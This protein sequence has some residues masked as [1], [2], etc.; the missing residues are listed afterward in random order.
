MPDDT[1]QNDSIPESELDEVLSGIELKQKL[2]KAFREADTAKSDLNE[3]FT[4]RFMKNPYD[5][6]IEKFEYNMLNEYGYKLSMWLDAIEM[7][8]KTDEYKQVIEE[9]KK[10][11][12]YKKDMINYVVTLSAIMENFCYVIARG[13][14]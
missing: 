14:Q 6:T 11:K 9:L 8:E 3:M 12:S 7:Y 10:P 1:N 4:Y 2:K 5:V 13:N